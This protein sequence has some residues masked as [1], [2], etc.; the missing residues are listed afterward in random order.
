MDVSS[1]FLIW[2]D[3]ILVGNRVNA[4]KKV[5]V[6]NHLVNF[7]FG[8]ELQR[9]D[10]H[11]GGGTFGQT[12][13]FSVDPYQPGAH[14]R[15]RFE[16]CTSTE[17]CI[18]TRAAFGEALA[19]ITNQLKFIGG[20]RWEQIALDYTPLP[21]RI[22]ASTKYYPT[23]GRVGAVYDL[24]SDV[25]M[26]VSYSR[27]VQPTTQL[28]ATRHLPVATFSLVPGTQFEV[29]SKFTSFGRRVDGTLAFYSIEKRDLLITTLVNNVSTNQQVGKQTSKG[30]E[31]SLL[32][33]PF[34]IHAR[35]RHC[36]YGCGI[37]RLHR[38]RKWG[39]CF[40][41]RKFS[42]ERSARGLEPYAFA[43]NW[44]GRCFGDYPSGWPALG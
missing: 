44:T 5:N 28:V 15:S 20:L 7:T 16:L 12:I 37:C 1:L 14:F 32:G 33:R 35:R 21:S 42:H 43:E 8:Q 2:R 22:T 36:V 13:R 25:N 6:G 23:T 38:N 4:R 9:N 18:N 31:L 17:Y 3:D 10:L 29:G 34:D 40:P 30:M 39:K 41:E 27:A 24:S 19:E 26:Y 11:R